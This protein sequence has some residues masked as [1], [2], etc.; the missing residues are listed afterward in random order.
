MFLEPSILNYTKPPIYESLNVIGFDA[1]L[2]KYVPTLLAW[3]KFKSQIFEVLNHRI[4]NAAEI[5][6]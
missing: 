4:D 1:A 2:Q 6:G 3:S 5:D